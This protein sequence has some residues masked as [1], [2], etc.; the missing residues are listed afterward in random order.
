MKIKFLN[1]KIHMLLVFTIILTT[2]FAS[3]VATSYADSI[4][5]AVGK[6]YTSSMA[7]SSSYPDTNGTELTNGQYAS[8]GFTDSQW[9]GRV[10]V[11]SYYQTVDLQNTNYIT[12]ISCRFLQDSS[13][14]IYWPDQVT[15]SFSVD[16]VSFT[17]LG[18]ATAQTVTSSVDKYSLALPSAVNARY[19]KMT[20]N[21]PGGWVFEDELE[22]LGIN[23]GS[24]NISRCKKYSSTVQPSPSYPD[25]NNKE[26]T[27]GVYASG[28][29]TDA[30]WQGRVG[31]YSQTVNL[32]TCMKVDKVTAN[33]L[34][35]LGGDVY[36]P[37]SVGVEY[38]TDGVNFT[39]LGNA[40]GGTPVNNTKKFSLTLAAPVNAKYIR[41]NVTAQAENYWVFTDEA[42]VLG[43]PIIS[44]S[45]I[46]PGYA[47]SW[48]QGDW[49]EEFDYMKDLGMDHL[50]IQWIIDKTPYEETVYYNSGNYNVNTGYTYANNHDTLMN[51]LSAAEVKGIDVWVGLAANDEWWSKS[52]DSTWLTNEANFNNAVIDDIWNSP[53]NYKNMSSFKGW[54]SVWEIDNGTFSAS[55]DQQKLRTALKTIVDHA[56]AVTGK[57]VMTSPYYN[58]TR[59]LDPSG[60][61]TMWTYILDNTNG[62]DFDVVAP[63]DGF[64]GGYI[65]TSTVGA[66]LGATKA[67]VDTNTGC[68]LWANVENFNSG[69]LTAAPM[70]R[71]VDQINTEIQYV[72]KMTSFSFTHYHSPKVV[73]REVYDDWKR[74]I[75]PRIAGKSYSG[76]VFGIGDIAGGKTYTVSVPASSSYPDT[77]GTELTNYKYSGEVSYKD[78][79]FQGRQNVPSYN[80][81]VDLGS[82]KTFYDMSLNFL[83]ETRSGIDFPQSV[84]FL[85]SSDNINFTTRGTVNYISD[86]L[87]T[88]ATKY[89]VS[90]QTPVTARYVKAV[91]TSGNTEWT[92]CDEFGVIGDR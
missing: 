59:G 29:F 60:W 16:G 50:I 62:A 14:G 61:Q 1:R 49:E 72:T 44:G 22:I 76:P 41:I 86:V 38:S 73:G 77:N 27:D 88:A 51:I 89:E 23:N 36:Y 83:R 56:H 55:V 91:I 46:Q 74:F 5:M 82:S 53:N 20:V 42:E 58:P 66:W 68:E 18:T 90:L 11:G 13:S 65:T 34:E 32:A 12:E 8:G 81:V 63:Q 15:Y 85:T 87:D 25:T 4:N 9:Q 43:S 84:E 10:N 19:I 33:F 45:F 67:A 75:Y 6:P 40:Q 64:G 69:D 30:A 2:V 35:Y 52:T 48:T 21:D 70:I 78:G 39:S 47:Y 3:G 31:S 28:V 37:S 71:V 92:M 17:N 26:L 57:P 54:Y 24:I 80:I 7:A 79:A